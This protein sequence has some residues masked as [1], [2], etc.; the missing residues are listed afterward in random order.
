[1]GTMKPEELSRPKIAGMGRYDVQKARFGL[2][3]AE[4]LKS[5]E[6]SRLNVHGQ[7][8]WSSSIQDLRTDLLG[9]VRARI[10]GRRKTEDD[11]EDR[12]C[13]GG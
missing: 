4:S 2:G 7:N 11:C 10:G 12:L 6:M 1:M 13:A 9:G 5:V 3:I 8:P